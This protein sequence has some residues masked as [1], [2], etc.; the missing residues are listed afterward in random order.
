[1]KKTIYLLSLIIASLS[2]FSQN[3]FINEDFSEGIPASW[4]VSTT[5]ATN[6]WDTTKSFNPNPLIGDITM[7]GAYA[8]T[9]DNSGTSN[10]KEVMITAEFDASTASK[11]SLKYDRIF[12]NFD[13]GATEYVDIHNG[14]SW[15]NLKSYTSIGEQGIDSVD[16]SAYKSTTNKLRFR[17]ESPSGG[18]TGSG[19]GIDNVQVFDPTVTDV[20]EGFSKQQTAIIITPNP[21][22]ELIRIRLPEVFPSK[23]KIYNSLGILVKQISADQREIT[24]SRDGLTDGL[25]IVEVSD[26]KTNKVIERKRLIAR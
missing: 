8:F 16:V 3:Y 6:Q 17:L 20:I 24:I 22:F 11:L 14:S 2:A 21:F 12:S 23:I 18:S 13:P 1:M 10:I 4:N 25:Y 26:A 7:D 15:S 9:F 5:G 19:F